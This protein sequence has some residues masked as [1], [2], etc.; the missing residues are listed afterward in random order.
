MIAE[1]WRGYRT[2]MRAR[3]MV[4]AVLVLAPVVAAGLAAWS[5]GGAPVS[6]ASPPRFRVL[7]F[8]KTTGFRHDSIRGGDRDDSP[9]RA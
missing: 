6:R 8:S 5:A 7:V 2:D 1:T 3:A 4:V 9:A